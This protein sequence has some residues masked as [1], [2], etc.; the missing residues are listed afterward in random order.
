MT[1]IQ[2]SIEGKE[3]VFAVPFVSAR[4]MKRAIQIQP[5]I[6]I[7]NLTAENVDIMADFMVE[8]YNNQFTADEVLDGMSN[9]D[10]SNA[11]L[12]TF[13]RAMM[14]DASADEVAGDIGH[15]ISEGSEGKYK[16][17]PTG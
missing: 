2:L 4:I 12:L 1:Q 17:Q 14:Q 13:F 11:F 10:F 8:A 15:I 5:H 6:D 3:K 7:N 9:K 16:P